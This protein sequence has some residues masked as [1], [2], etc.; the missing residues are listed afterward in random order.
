MFLEI[1][2]QFQISGQHYQT[3]FLFFLTPRS[4]NHCNV[5]FIQKVLHLS[6]YKMYTGLE[7]QD[8][9]EDVVDG[10]S[11][12][13]VGHLQN[14]TSNILISVA[15]LLNAKI[16]VEWSWNENNKLDTWFISIII[17]PKK[18]N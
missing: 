14:I 4:N 8:V 15:S 9:I 3:I 12:K 17:S 11:N 2:E 18:K 16:E 6:Q 1:G 7:R 13:N 5:Y 10:E